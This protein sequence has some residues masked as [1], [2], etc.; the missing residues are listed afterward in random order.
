MEIEQ[1]KVGF[2]EVFCYIVSCEN[3]KEALVIDPAGDEDFVVERINEKGLNLRYIVNTHGHADHVCGNEKIKKLTGA[4][5]VMHE[6][7]DTLFSSP[8]GRNRALRMG[9]NPSPEADLHVKDNDEIVVGNVK[10]KVI[11]TPRAHSGRNMPL[12]GRE[13]FCGRYIVCRRHRAH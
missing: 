9:F 12:R 5:I 3:T 8:E 13:P 2:M 4:D 7:D 1:I 10:L 6:E 11:H